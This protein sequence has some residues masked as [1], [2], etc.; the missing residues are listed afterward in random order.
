MKKYLYSL[1]L[2]IIL[3]GMVFAGGAPP[4]APQVSLEASD[5]LDGGSDPMDGDKIEISRTWDNITPDHTGDESDSDDDLAAILEGIDD[6]LGTKLNSDGSGASLTGIPLD[7]DFGSNGLMERTGAGTYG[8]ATEGPEGDYLGP[9]RI[10]DTKGDG[11]TGYLYSADKIHDELAGK[12][13][14]HLNH[15]YFASLTPASDKLP[16]FDSAGSMALADLTAFAR[17]LLDDSDAATVRTT[18]GLVIDTDVQ[19]YDSA[20]AKTDEPETLANTWTVN[21]DKGI[22]HGSDKDVWI[23]YDSSDARYALKYAVDSTA[24]TDE[25]LDA[26]ETAITVDDS[27]LLTANEVIKVES[28]YMSVS[29]IDD[30]TTI[31]VVRGALGST[32]AIHT[33]AKDIYELQT[34]FAFDLANKTKCSIPTVNPEVII[35][36]SDNPGSDKYSVSIGAQYVDG[37][38]GSENNDIY[39]YANKGGNKTTIV[40]YDESADEWIFPAVIIKG[41]SPRQ[42]IA[43]EFTTSVATGDGAFYFHVD[44]EIEGMNLVDVHAEHITC[45]LYTSPSPRDATLSRMPSSA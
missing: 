40:K 36:D 23:G 31:T 7:A 18:L 3:S 44:K 41:Y 12:Q 1:I 27:S 35:N 29:S 15:D 9:S 19:S 5:L 20:T 6:A 4:S 24:N 25:E 21:D 14:Y 33:T 39:I 28:E 43:F 2:L 38:D 8:I 26:S 16:Y 10:D 13:D 17:S 42:V 34:V 37:V 45:L 30:G 22:F 11:D 32:A